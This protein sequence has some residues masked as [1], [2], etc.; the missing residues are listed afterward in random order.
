MNCLVLGGAGFI[1][2]HLCATLSAAGHRVRA[3]DLPP[4]G[5]AQKWPVVGGVDW[6][7]GNFTK[8]GSLDGLLD[9]VEVVFH[10][11][12]TTLPATS[13]EDMMHDLQSNVAATLRLLDLIVSQTKPPRVIFI[14]SGGTVYGIPRTTPITEDHPTNPI[15]AYGVSKLTIEK[16]L[17]VY[18]HLYDLEYCILRLSNVYGTNQSL[19]RNQGVI[20]I[21][22]FRALNRLPLKLWG[23]GNVVRDYLYIGD[24][25]EALLATMEYRGPER[26]FNIGSGQGHSLNNLIQI[27]SKTVGHDVECVSLPGRVWDVPQNILDPGQANR[28]LGWSAKTPLAKGI[29]SLLPWLKSL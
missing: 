6:V 11:I 13:N 7:P 15:C 4:K 27:I 19:T 16:Y 17:C 5:S 22:L 10:L 23:D 18:N 24:L 2:R 8:A 28:E 12:G 9:D 3:F 14:S 21:F 25:C 26:I 29:A 1:G 20:P